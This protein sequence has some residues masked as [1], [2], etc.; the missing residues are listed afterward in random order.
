MN[1]ES[2]LSRTLVIGVCLAFLA[3]PLHADKVK[4]EVD[5][6]RRELKANI[7]SVLSLQRENDGKLSEDRI[8]RLHAQ[9]PAEIG[10]ALQPFG[11]YKPQV[12]AE[13]RQEGKEWIAHYDVDAGPPIKVATV[14]L[15]IAGAG[16][17]EPRFRDIES[18]F[19][20]K[21]GDVL[22]HPAYE[23]G[24]KALTDLAAEEGYL[25]AAFQENQVRVDL[26]RY[27]ADVVLHF[28]TGPR[29]LFGPVYFHQDVLD[30]NLLTGYI[31]FKPGEPLDV[32]K[33]LQ[34]QNALSD[35]PY[36]S[37]VEVVTRQDRAEGLEVPIDVNLVPAKT[38]RFSGG[39]GYGTDTGPRLKGTLDLRRLN[40][41]GHRAQFQLNVSQIEQNFLSSYIIPGAYPRTDTLSYNL[42]YDRQITRTLDSKTGLVGAQYTQLRGGWNETYSL[43]Y[44][45]ETYK[46]GLDKGTSK[47]LVPSAGLERVK[48]DDRIYTTNGYRLRLTLQ[49]AEKSALSD[50]TFLQGLVDAKVIRTVGD[51]N[52]LIG[53][54]QIGYTATSEFRQLPPR[55]RFFAGGDQSVRG[56]RYETLGTKDEAGNVIGG[57]ALLVGSLEYE[58]RF[59]PK[60]GVAAF[61]DA[62][63]AFH[64]FSGVSLAQGVGAG[65]RWRSPIGPVRAD[66][67]F[68]LTGSRHSIV[69]HLNIGPDL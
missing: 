12:R 18:G 62:G 69:F 27:R 50:A 64:N 56:Y 13:L 9:A 17:Q 60:W 30:G 47:L 59:L 44:E 58:Y 61:Y 51:R 19:P 65:V 57:E 33:V 35:S 8:R 21:P 22:F 40:R 32:N 16:A 7:L 3:P 26:Q 2:L 68:G 41:R 66:V 5:G 24:K 1:A 45:L 15:T 43:N 38:M 52:R 54:T 10:E 48:A 53:R 4:V 42:A 49:G 46:V 28:D 63:N 11:Y 31:T 37:R 23:G 36:W 34:L 20:V 39:V 6:V 14:D 55:F 25:D 67:G 29:Y